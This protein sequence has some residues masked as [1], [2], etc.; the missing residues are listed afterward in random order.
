MITNDT[1]FHKSTK[2]FGYQKWHHMQLVKSR[3]FKNMF[4][5]CDSE[6]DWLLGA[7]IGVDAEKN[8][9]VLKLMFS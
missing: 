9:Q 6:I 1:N 7:I 8:N 3:G 4:Q 2:I 5:M